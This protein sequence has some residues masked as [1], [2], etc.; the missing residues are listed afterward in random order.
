[1]TLRS[2]IERSLF[3]SAKSLALAHAN[4]DLRSFAGDSRDH[5]Y[6]QL[7]TEDAPIWAKN[8]IARAFELK[9]VLSKLASNDAYVSQEL[10]SEFASGRTEAILAFAARL[11]AYS[12]ALT[13][14]GEEDDGC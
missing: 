5:L 14:L 4:V 11:R 10:A 2:S 6:K 12:A 3:V 8:L 7:V 9:A 1:M 13:N